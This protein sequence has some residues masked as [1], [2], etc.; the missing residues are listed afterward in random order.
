M[1]RNKNGIVVDIRSSKLS[2]ATVLSQD[3]E[4]LELDFVELQKFGL[5]IIT[6]ADDP[7]VPEY[8]ADGY[9]EISR[10]KANVTVPKRKEVQVCQSNKK[11]ARPNLVSDSSEIRSADAQRCRKIR[12]NGCR[13][14]FNSNRMD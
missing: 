14:R 10:F 7:E 3:Y 2:S 9:T 6:P 12:S 8:M 13:Q 4:M 5:H 1:Q 11:C